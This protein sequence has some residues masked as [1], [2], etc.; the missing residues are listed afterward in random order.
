[1]LLRPF[2]EKLP[3]LSSINANQFSKILGIYF[4]ANQ[5]NDRQLM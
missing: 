3:E 2:L 5:T 4:A 1:M